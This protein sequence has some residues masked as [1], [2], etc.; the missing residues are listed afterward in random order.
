VYGSE[1]KINGVVPPIVQKAEDIPKKDIRNSL[2]NTGVK[3]KFLVF[4]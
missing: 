2:E 1:F 4:T 3:K